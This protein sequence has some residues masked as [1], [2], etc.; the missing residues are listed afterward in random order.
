MFKERS[1]FDFAFIP[2]GPYRE[3]V[4]LIRRGEALG[5]RC[6]WLPDQTFHRDPFV[7]L[8][9]C[10]EATSEIGLG[11]GLTS[12][13]TRLP[14]Q[15]AR[16]A[17]V[18]DEV[19]GGRFILG[20]GTANPKTV[21]APLNITLDRPI[22]R[23]RDAIGI[24]RRLLAGERVEYEG[25]SDMLNGVKLDFSPRPDIPIYIGTRGPQMLKLAGEVADGVLVESLFNALPQVLEQ[26][27]SGAEKSG[28][29]LRDVDVVAWQLVQVT[30]DVET[31]IAAQKS[32][33]A[34]SISIGP[35]QA[36]RDV[37]IDETVIAG[38]SEAMARGDQ[39]T[40]ISRVTDDAV[41]CLMIIG[42]ATQVSERISRV[43]GSGADSLNLLLMGSMASMRET[44]ERFARD[45]MPAF[46]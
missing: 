23:L 13:Y 22:G 32:W 1:R 27:R 20:L 34:R 39:E 36:M 29:S 41:R 6:A 10:A 43:F 14:V 17:G 19:A 11:C 5:Y 37:G 2:A 38:V 31:A 15:I 33:I 44:L 45:V 21:L 3:T 4:D 46:R 7:L 12:P 42:N 28:R 16:A 26:V 24:I 8:G 9:L 35:Y 40:A 30:D 25:A 18:V